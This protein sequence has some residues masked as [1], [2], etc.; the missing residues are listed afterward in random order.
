[1]S[2][3]MATFDYLYG[4]M[5]GELILNHSDNL[6]R[7]LQKHDISA[8]QGQEVAKLTVQTL[9]KIRSEDA[10]DLFWK[11]VGIKANSIELSE[12]QL[13]RRRIVPRRYESGSAEP[14]YPVTP[15]DYYKR[16]YL[17][18]LDLITSCIK[19]RFEQPGYRVY[20]HLQELLLKSAC[21][22]DYQSEYE[23]VTT[24]YGLDFT[25]TLKAQ[26]QSF[27]TLFSEESKPTLTLTDINF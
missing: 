10:F 13:P 17:E 12:P 21:G 6:S 5:L 20:R 7:T 2:S 25:H 11:K 23:F 14:E 4:V 8:A 19:D 1:M 15:Y 9:Q 18:A 27:T 24:F 3:Q 16:I 22:S 26:L